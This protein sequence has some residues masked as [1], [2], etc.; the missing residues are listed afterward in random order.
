MKYAEFKAVCPYEIGDKIKVIQEEREEVHT[1]T[2]IVCMHY[3][4]TGAVQFL[5]ELDNSGKLVH[6]AATPRP[7]QREAATQSGEIRQGGLHDENYINY[8]PER[9]RC[10]D[11]DR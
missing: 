6:I 8:Q 5:F 11:A 10:K 3:L 9:R 7:E 2:D 4:K 1:I